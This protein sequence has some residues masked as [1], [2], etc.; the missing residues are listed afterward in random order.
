MI[1][2]FLFRVYGAEHLQEEDLKR[3]TAL[4]EE[5]ESTAYFCILGSR[6][7]QSKAR[8]RRI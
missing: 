4:L 8:S 2:H 1:K 3:A 7:E 6:S 5:L